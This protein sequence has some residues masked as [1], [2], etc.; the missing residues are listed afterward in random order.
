MTIELGPLEDVVTVTEIDPLVD[1]R[2]RLVEPVDD[3]DL[4]SGTV[5]HVHVVQCVPGAVRGNHVHRKC[6]ES[7]CLIAGDFRVK[8]KST[9]SGAEAEFDVPDGSPVR[10]E[11]PAGIG[12]TFKNVGTSTGY[13]LAYADKPFDDSDF[14]RCELLEP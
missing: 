3:A 10:I 6:Q 11:V 9:V 12:H 13:I 5:L 4:R 1:D 8:L 2:G 7:F 14:E